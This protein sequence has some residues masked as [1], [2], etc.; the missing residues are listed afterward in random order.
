MMSPLDVSAE[1]EAD[2][3]DLASSASRLLHFVKANDVSLLREQWDELEARTLRHLDAEEMVLLPAFERE[4]ADDGAKIR[5]AHARIRAMLGEGGIALDLHILKPELVVALRD[6]L[7]A[8][9][10]HEAATLYTWTRA[11][12]D[13]ARA[14]GVERGLSRGEHAAPHNGVVAALRELLTICEDGEEGYRLAAADVRDEG[15]RLMLSRYAD[16]RSAFAK[17]LRQALTDVGASA[18]AKGS[19]LGAVHRRWLDA[20]ATLMSG[21]P[22]AVL[23]E[24]ERGED[25]ALEMYRAA[26]RVDL[27]PSVREI[28]QEQYGSLKAAHAEICSLLGEEK[29]H[30]SKS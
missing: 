7:A 2:H 12:A 13:H 15:Y 5:D 29:A 23:A 10:T 11:N 25:A 20:R 9:A 1:L 3:Q 22:R 28:V 26:L 19:I 17:A 24:C 6:A 27:R 21:D 8:H 4:H 30:G 18:P 16:E 14:L